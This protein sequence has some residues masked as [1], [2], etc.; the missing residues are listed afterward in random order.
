[1]PLSSPSSA[2]SATSGNGPSPTFLQVVCCAIHGVAERE[3]ANVG[4]ERRYRAAD[5]GAEGQRQRLAKGALAFADQPVPRPDDPLPTFGPAYEPAPLDFP[6]WALCAD[7]VGSVAPVTPTRF[8]L[9]RA[10]NATGRQSMQVA[11]VL[12][13]PLSRPSCYGTH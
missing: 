5:V 7:I 2:A 8:R 13:C 9:L 10:T 6:K 1:M 4:T 12:W 3:H 11:S